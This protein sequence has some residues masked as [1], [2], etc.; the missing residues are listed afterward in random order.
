M[1]N[2]FAAKFER[3]LLNKRANSYTERINGDAAPQRFSIP[4]AA[5]CSAAA[6]YRH[7]TA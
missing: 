2:N 1:F 7:Y 5:T 6:G 3:R 4:A